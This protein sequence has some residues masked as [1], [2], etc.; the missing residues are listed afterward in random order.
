M[1]EIQFRRESL[2]RV[3]ASGVE[4]LLERHWREI[5]H[6]QD[7]PLE[8]DWAKYEAA[9]S[10][11]NLRIFTARAD[12]DLIG[13]GCY[14][15][16]YNGHYRSSLQAVQDVLFLVP[17][18]RK[19]RIGYRLIAYADQQLREEGVQAVYQHSKAAHDMSPILKRQGYVL[20]D[21]LYAKRLDQ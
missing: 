21:L 7:I 2:T 9:E 13:Y 19:A 3:R 11:G 10:A 20:V 6:F 1:A 18:H 14:L 4:A 12:L 17:E 5:A 8:V 15:V 16:G